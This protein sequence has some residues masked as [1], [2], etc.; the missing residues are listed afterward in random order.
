MCSTM[1]Y[2]CGKI[3]PL[4]K[5]ANHHRN[6]PFLKFKLNQGVLTKDEF[7]EYV[8]EGAQMIAI[9]FAEK[10]TPVLVSQNS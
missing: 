2:C 5:V 7:F 10:R 3:V 1:N 4:K 8:N 6:T 9:A